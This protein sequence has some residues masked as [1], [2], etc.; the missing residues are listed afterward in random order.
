MHVSNT[1]ILGKHVIETNPSKF[2]EERERETDT[3]I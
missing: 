1:H 3:D 2:D